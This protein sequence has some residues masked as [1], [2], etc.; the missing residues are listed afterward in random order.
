[1]YEW[2]A[3]SARGKQ[4]SEK[5]TIEYHHGGNTQADAENDTGKRQRTGNKG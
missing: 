5:T 3:T 4:A 1:M 2:T